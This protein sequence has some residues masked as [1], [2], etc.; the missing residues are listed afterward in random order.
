[1]KA[2]YRWLA[3]LSNGALP[4]AEEVAR[5]LTSGGLEVEGST[6]YG[7]ACDK[8]LVARVTAKEPHPQR[9]KLTLVT[10]D[11]GGKSQRVVCGAPNVPDVGGL[12]V[13]APLGTHLPAKG[14][15]LEPREIAGVVSEGM[16]CSES[17][18][19]LRISG[20]E[21]GIL[22]L[23]EGIAAPGT[24]LSQAIPESHDVVFEV[25][26]T[27]NRPDGLGHLGL[28]RDLA[29]VMGRKLTHA[30]A[31]PKR[32][33]AS[34]IADA[35]TITVEDGERCPTYGAALV[36]NVKVAPS[37]LGSQYRLE[38]LGVRAISNVVDITNLVMLK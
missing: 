22:I 7:E 16:L 38:A 19:G 33:T 13:L 15:T 28:A 35:V 24:P 4:P 2:S 23:P 17:E 9:A 10:V 11:L 34:K 8:A 30:A 26:L 5:L 36:E 12:V 37:P 32:P 29:A 27:P 6:R 14:V 31:Q 3:E 20:G 1:M 25:N 18:L 21:A